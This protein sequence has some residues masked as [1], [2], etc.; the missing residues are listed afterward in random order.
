MMTITFK[1]YTFH[2]ALGKDSRRTLAASFLDPRRASK[3]SGL[4]VKIFCLD[5]SAAP[6]QKRCYVPELHDLVLYKRLAIMIYS[7]S[8]YTLFV[9]D[10]V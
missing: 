9:I 1:D 7:V 6:F 5:E 10:G 8:N 2:R 3:I 4:L